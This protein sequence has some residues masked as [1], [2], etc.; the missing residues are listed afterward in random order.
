MK[1]VRKRIAEY[2]Y[3][4][5]DKIAGKRPYWREDLINDT[6]K[7]NSENSGEIDRLKDEFRAE[8]EHSINL[9]NALVWQRDQP[10]AAKERVAK[11]LKIHGKRIRGDA[12]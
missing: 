5:S 7:K 2:V 9:V 4:L 6:R 1:N 3:V 11:L 12:I 10:S 8:R